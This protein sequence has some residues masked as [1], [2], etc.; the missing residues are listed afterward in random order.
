M[1]LVANDNFAGNSHL[2]F[3]LSR[4]VESGKILNSYVFSG[5]EGIGKKTLSEIFIKNIFCTSLKDGNACGVCPFCKQ[6]ESSNFPDLI[7]L[8]KVKDKKT[9]GIEEVREQIIKN[10]Y[11]KP[12]IAHKKVFLIKEGDDL[13]IDAQNGL[14]KV[15]EEPPEYVTF[16]IL[17]TKTS[18]LLDTVLS[19]SCVLNLH[20]ATKEETVNYLKNTYPDLNDEDILFGA[21]FSQ[22]VIG[23]AQKILFD[24]EYKALFFE[25]SKNLDGLCSS[26]EGFVSFH[27]FMLDN[28]DN[29]DIIIDFML[30]YLR[31]GLFCAEGLSDMAICPENFKAKEITHNLEGVYTRLMDCVIKY[32]NMLSANANFTVLTLN[33]ADEIQKNC[34]LN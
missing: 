4:F 3:Q 14:L 19:R 9:I 8:K 13:T 28:K 32:K 23:K 24:E 21:R 31:D 20:P 29:V 5:D 26:K 18:R 27:R 1:I 2:L 17:V 30:I 11:I 16:I 33:L 6:I 22:G 15:L 7:T 12:F 25:T 34:N 10:A